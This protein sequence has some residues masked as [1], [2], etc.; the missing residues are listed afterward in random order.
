[1]YNYFTR[2]RQKDL[3]YTSAA[4]A[5][6]PPITIEPEV[7]LNKAWAAIEVAD[8]FSQAVEKLFLEAEGRLEVDP[9][10]YNNAV[11]TKN[12]LLRLVIDTGNAS[13]AVRL[14]LPSLVPDILLIAENLD[15]FTQIL[16]EIVLMFYFHRINNLNIPNLQIYKDRFQYGIANYLESARAA[17]LRARAL[18]EAYIAYK[19]AIN[20]ELSTPVPVQDLVNLINSYI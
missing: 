2:S 5:F 1:M 13:N 4:A 19:A 9:T 16:K 18:V 20:A 6:L 3:L 14:I 11:E 15:D 12:T 8:Q 10:Y 7:A 17:A